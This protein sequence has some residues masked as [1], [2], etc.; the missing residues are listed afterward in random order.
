MLRTSHDWPA[1][2]QICPALAKCGERSEPSG[3]RS[4]PQMPAGLVSS[5]RKTNGSEKKLNLMQGVESWTTRPQT[6]DPTTALTS[7]WWHCLS[8]FFYWFI[9]VLC[10]QDDRLQKV[11]NRWPRIA[12]LML[13]LRYNYIINTGLGRRLDWGCCQH[14]F[15]GGQS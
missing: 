14:L 10:P 15:V 3:Q 1:G 8:A 7:R 5:V 12:M 13:P 4:W 11:P 9:A 2:G 6:G